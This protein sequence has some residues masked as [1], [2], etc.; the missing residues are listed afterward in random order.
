MLKKFT[1]LYRLD[2][3][4][5]VKKKPTFF[6]N[7]KGVLT[8]NPESKWLDYLEWATVLTLL[9]NNGAESV[10]FGCIKN[11]DGY[12]A[13]Y[14]NGKNPFIEVWVKIDG[15]QFQL[16]YPVIDGNKVEAEP[17]Q[18]TINKAQQR[19]FVKCVAINTGLGLKLWQ[20][21]ESTFDSLG[22]TYKE[23]KEL[24]ELIPGSDKWIEAIKAIKNGYTIQ[25]IEK[26]YYISDEN[27]D[28][29]LR[30]SI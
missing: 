27:R 24:P 25:Q 15:K 19:G 28:E 26:K 12:P 7:D 30:Q 18:M 29:L 1:D 3:K 9:Y 4:S 16:D 8:K 23:A 2:I 17:N 10:E 11:I 21:E 14:N 13:F 5:D 22:E 6:K 20:K